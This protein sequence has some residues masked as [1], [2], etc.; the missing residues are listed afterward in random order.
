MEARTSPAG[1]LAGAPTEGPPHGVNIIGYL[2]LQAGLT[3]A[4]RMNAA[5]IEATGLPVTMNDFPSCLQAPN[6]LHAKYDTNY[7][8][9]QPDH[10]V[11]PTNLLA[12]I[13]LHRKSIGYWAWE[14]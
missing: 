6:A 9:F 1:Q 10:W 5:A 4:C 7:F 8:H 11:L 2:S 12:E 14:T 13:M 3:A